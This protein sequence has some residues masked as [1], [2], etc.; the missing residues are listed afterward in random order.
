MSYPCEEAWH[1]AYVDISDTLG[2]GLSLPSGRNHQRTIV[3]DRLAEQL[4]LDTSQIADAGYLAL[5]RLY[6]V[7]NAN[8]TKRWEWADDT[9]AERQKQLAAEA[10]ARLSSDEIVAAMHQFR[11]SHDRLDCDVTVGQ[12]PDEL[13][14]VLA[15]RYEARLYQMLNR[16]ARNGVWPASH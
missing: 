16:W 7:L 4:T 3:L 9:I 1:L 11:W 2:R 10:A 15:A 13:R 14:R 8:L 5:W 6:E 12:V